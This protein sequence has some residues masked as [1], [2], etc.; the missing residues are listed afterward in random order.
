MR[1]AQRLHRRLP[2]GRFLE[3]GRVVGHSH[4]AAPGVDRESPARHH[5]ADDRPEDRDLAD[6]W[7]DR[8]QDMAEKN[9]SHLV[10]VVADMAKSDPP[11]PARSWRN[12]ASACRGKVRCCIWRAA[13]SNSGWWTRVVHRTAGPVGKPKPGGRPGFRQP[14]HR[15]PSFPERHGLEGVRGDP[16]PGRGDFALRPGRAS[17]PRW[18]L[19]PAIA[20]AI[21]SSSG[22]AQPTLRS[23]RRAARHP[24]GRGQRPANWA[25]GPDRPCGLYL[26]DK[27]RPRL[28]AKRGGAVALANHHRTKHP[29]FPL[30]FYVGG[31]GL[32]TLLATFGSCGRRGM[33]GVPD[34]THFL[35]PG[36]PALR[37]QLAVALMNWLS[38]LL[39][40]P[41]CSRAWIFLRHRRRL[42]HHGGRAHDAHEH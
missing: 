16:E 32:L 10:I 26:I 20:I 24:T 2:N 4:H 22:P 9:P 33:L 8:L 34:G 35:H 39:V 38:T 36:F 11:S 6:L 3:T 1:A 14:Q 25:R 19:R 17:T 41:A 7:V 12:S 15:Q 42:P 40:K 29:P 18:I 21:R 27:G 28:G 37:S 23:G 30:T 13:G 31:I 5:P